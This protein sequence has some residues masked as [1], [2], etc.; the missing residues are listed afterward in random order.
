MPASYVEETL[1]G[2]ITVID[3]CFNRETLI[4]EAFK[5]N[6]TSESGRH[7]KIDFRMLCHV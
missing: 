5:V 7:R 6:E 2:H 3:F 1:F 4:L